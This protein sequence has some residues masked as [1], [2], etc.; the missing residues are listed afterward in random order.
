MGAAAKNLAARFP[1]STIYDVKVSNPYLQRA[2]A[3]RSGAGIAVLHDVAASDNWA[4]Q[5][6]PPLLHARVRYD[7]VH[8]CNATAVYN[9]ILIECY[10][11]AVLTFVQRFIGQ[12]YEDE[13]VEQ[14]IARLTYEVVPQQ[15]DP[16]ARE[17]KARR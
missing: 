8:V 7:G 10:F 17:A 16:Q 11:S 5:S 4:K 3:K 6:L 14:D 1:A 13:G 2:P 12:R 15:P 9:T